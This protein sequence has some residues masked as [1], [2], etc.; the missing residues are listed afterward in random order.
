MIEY[1]EHTADVRMKVCS[2]SIP[3]L[4]SEALLGL[5]H[6]CAPNQCDENTNTTFEVKI[7]SSNLETLLIDFLSE[8]LAL[9]QIHYVIF[10]QIEIHTLTQTFLH[11][12]IFGKPVDAFEE[13]IKSI[14]YHESQIVFDNEH[15]CATIVFDL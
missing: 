9:M 1:L 12:T 8:V 10:C 14:T 6:Y 3:G 4:F 13:E 11:A 2:P 5:S 7:Q 15:Y